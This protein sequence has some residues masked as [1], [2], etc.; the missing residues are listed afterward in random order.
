MR[1]C[2][3]APGYAPT[4]GGV[5]TQ[6]RELSERLVARGHSVT[7]H[8]AD[9]SGHRANSERRNGV[10]VH[11]HRGLTINDAYHFAPQVALSIRSGAFDIVHVHNLHALLFP[12]ALLASDT[13]TVAT[14]YYHGHSAS[15]FRDRLLRLY[16]PVAR[17]TLHAADRVTTVSEWERET[18]ARDF[19]VDAAVV[20]LGVDPET[21]DGVTPA[22]RDRPY[23]L[24]V[25]RLLE[26]KGVQDIV[27][28]LAELPEYDLLVAGDGPYRDR[29]ASHAQEVGVAS[30]VELLGEIDHDRLARLYAGATTHVT[31][32][33]FE[34]FGLTVAES[35]LAG[36]PCVVRAAT[37]LRDWCDRPDVVCVDDSAPS[38]VA[39]AVRRAAD[40]AAPA[41]SVLSWDDVTDC[42][43]TIYAAVTS[44]A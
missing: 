12:F 14:T 7:V 37:A 31:L 18:V 10:T 29:V 11:R 36:T 35:L 28:A 39:A 21:F 4:T 9:A 34:S 20:P 13:P 2:Q 38:T 24:C 27:A 43:E 8:T 23:L 16:R 41:E 3:V 42:Y 17:R 26:Y 32:S 33:T 44:P 22:S 15:S 1:I 25:A 5:E 19:G 6:V 40:L 30:R